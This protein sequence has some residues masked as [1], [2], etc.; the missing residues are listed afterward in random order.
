MEWMLRIGNHLKTYQGFPLSYSTMY[1]SYTSIETVLL[2]HWVLI[3]ISFDAPTSASL[4]DLLNVKFG[5]GIVNVV[6]ASN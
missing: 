1:V 5:E 2:L 3:N 4:D 6:Y